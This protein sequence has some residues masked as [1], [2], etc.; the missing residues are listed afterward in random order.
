MESLAAQAG[1]A[2]KA[3]RDEA[4]RAYN[5]Q[6]SEARA[7][8]EQQR[9]EAD[10][11]ARMAANRFTQEQ[12]TLR[13][14][15]SAQQSQQARE[16]AASLE[17]QRMQGE[18][19]LLL[20]VIKVGDLNVARSNIEFLLQ[21]GLVRDNSGKIALAARQK[22]PVL[23]TSSGSLEVVIPTAASAE[24][25]A[26]VETLGQAVQTDRSSAQA[27]RKPLSDLID[28]IGRERERYSVRELAVILAVI[29]NHTAGTFH[30]TEERCSARM[31]RAFRRIEVPDDIDPES[32]FER[33]YG[34]RLGNTNPGD[35]YRYR[36]RDYFQASGR[37]NY[38]RLT[39]Q[40]KTDYLANPDLLSQPV[41]AF[42]SV[43]T[44]SERGLRL[45]RE[46]P[47]FEVEDPDD[48]PY[49]EALAPVIRAITGGLKGLSEVAR[50]AAL[51]ETVL[52]Q[53]LS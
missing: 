10:A 33:M 5:L 31:V 27:L 19:A 45:L 28:A 12:M 40:W 44:F 26:L 20:E 11:A 3:R 39:R 43:L 51:I 29:E 41:H 18:S 7:K 25:R 4:T 14:Q 53:R 37:A 6:A 15:N 2:E 46:H 30:P 38:E 16:F 49:A 8:I 47:K 52:R 34:G 42:R 32:C 36:G 13:A 21:A 22:P 17:R 35:A 1:L 24:G 50:R 9:R 23:P 48:F